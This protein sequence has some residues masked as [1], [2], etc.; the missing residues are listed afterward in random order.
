MYLMKIIATLISLWLVSFL[1]TG[2]FAIAQ[3]NEALFDL[4]LSDLLDIE[5]TTASKTSQ[6]ISEAPSIISVITSTDIKNMGARDIVDVLR[7]APGFDLV[8]HDAEPY[9][10]TSIRGISNNNKIKMMINGHT[11]GGLETEF[12]ANF[13]IIPIAS[14]ERIEIIR[15]P[16]SALYGAGAFTGV[17]NII[18]KKGKQ[19]SST[20]SI[21][22][23][24]F[25]MLKP[26]CELSL[27]KGDF[28]AYVYADYYKTDGYKAIIESDMTV[29]NPLFDGAVP[30][31]MTNDSKHLSI[32]TN[33]NYK[34][35]SF[36]GLFSQLYSD[37][38]IGMTN[39]LTDENEIVRTYAYG[40]LGVKQPMWDRGNL[41]LKVYYDYSFRDDFFELF[42]EET[43]ALHNNTFAA[44]LPIGRPFNDDEGLYGGPKCKTSIMGSE[45][46]IDYEV[47][48]EVL[49]VAGTFY[50]RDKQYDV[51]HLANFN[52][53]GA[54]L[55]IDGIEYPA[56]PWVAFPDGVTDISEY[57]N[58][59]SNASRTILGV[60]GQGSLDVRQLLSL[61][62]GVNAL[63]LITGIR[64]DNFNDV[65]SSLN[66]R[67]G[68][69]YEPLEKL[70]FKVLYG[71]A[72]RT[73]SFVELY[74]KNN[75]STLGNED[76][77]P[78][79]IKTMETLI[80]YDFSKN[81]RANITYFNISLT[82]LIQAVPIGQS[83]LT[84]YQNLGKVKGSGM[85]AE[86][87]VAIDKDKYGYLNITW[88]NIKN[89]TH[90][91]IVSDSGQTYTQVDF[92]PPNI[93]TF[94]GNIGINYDIFE[95]M[96]T[97]VSINYVGEK[98]RSERKMWFGEQLATF[99]QRD[100]IKARV[101]LNASI[102][103]R[104][105]MKGFEIQFSGYNL[106]DADHRDPDVRQTII[107]DFPQPGRSF[108][109]RL[110]YS[111]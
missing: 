107:N 89:I 71:Q 102:T 5:V 35:F 37:A 88:Q 86:L 48:S 60:Y 81:V 28:K 105:F 46:T 62:K 94:Y 108:A 69:V 1:L 110:S 103:L 42:P 61:E 82:D 9:H 30:G 14:I 54:P 84:Q 106:L 25:A 7:T 2:N 44:N 24:S 13:N 59:S 22:A 33:L 73:P 83:G 100:P 40:E 17:I 55:V 99:D 39:T 92:T 34:K 70:F 19:N 98:K 77:T 67:F 85:E 29:N 90:N 87:K 111:L 96:I 91:A 15:G 58:W 4:S 80:G 3:D 64:Y 68:V 49:L 43:G 10:V 65:G 66:P 97:N 38:P 27:N 75:P 52:T 101:L 50:E 20:L 51:R 79:K 74:T 72:F 18:T 12:R 109:A 93:P 95:F 53:T 6:K 23:G 21:E 16:G 56:F 32:Q 11:P 36:H 8:M 57:A 76:L 104:N 47:S 78:E 63:S 45:F 26:Y 41:Q 31:E